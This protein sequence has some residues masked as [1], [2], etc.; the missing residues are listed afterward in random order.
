LADRY[1]IERELGRGGM[2][3]VWL[4]RDL[5][6]DRSIALKVLH[7]ELA[8]ALGPDRFLR[9]IR[10]AAGLQHPHILP[11]HDSGSADGLLWYTMPYV[12]GESLRGRLEREPQLPLEE[13]VRIG[14]E[15]ADGLSY[16]HRQGIIHRDIKPENILLSDGH[17]LIADFGLARA[18]EAAGADRLTESGIAVGTPAYMSPEQASC[19]ARL[20]A[21]SDLYALGCVVYEMLAG[22]PPFQG[23]TAQ[24]I[25][26]RRMSEPVRPLRPVRNVPESVER[27]VLTALERSPADRF[28]DVAVFSTALRSALATTGSPRPGA[29]R[30]L[31]TLAIAGSAGAAFLA[32]GYL[33]SRASTPAAPTLLSTGVLRNRERLLIA[34]FDNRTADSLLGPAVTEAFRTDLAGS[35]VIGVV[36]GAKVMATLERMRRPRTARLDAELA[37]EVA[38]RDGIKAVVTG[39][40]GYAGGQYL[41][42]AQLMATSTGDVLVALRET[43][44]DSSRIVS[45]IDRLSGDLR[46][47]IG[48]SVR[49]VRAE[50]PLDQVTTGSLLALWK[51]SEG[52]RAGDGEGDFA[53][54]VALLE[55]A[56]ALDTAFATAYRTLGG[57]YS[58]LGDRKREV[59]AL[60][61]AH[62]HRGRLSEL[63]LAHTQAHYH[64]AVTGDLHQAASA[65]RA[66]LERHPDDSVAINNLGAMALEMN[67]PAVAESIFRGVDTVRPCAPSCLPGGHLNLATALIALG[68]RSEAERVYARG[69]E[70]MPRSRAMQW[71][72][73]S[74]ASSA[75]DYEAAEARARAIKDRYASD[76][77]DR[78]RASR[79]LAAIALTR[80]RLAEAEREIGEALTASVEAGRQE[81]YLRDVAALGYI[82][83]WFRGRPAQGRR[84]VDAAVARYPLSSI[85]V[86]ERPYLNLALFYAAA[87]QP[88]RAR[89]LLRAYEGD[90]QP[91]LRR[92]NE[93]MRRWTWGHVALAEHRFPEAIAAFRA[94]LRSFSNCLPCGQAALALAYDRAGQTDSAIVAYER[95]VETP[96]SRLGYPGFLDDAT[97][98]APALRRLGELYQARGDHV[99][100]AAY[101][102]RFAT[103]WE[104]ADPELRPAVTAAREEL[105]HLDRED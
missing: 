15:I 66:V 55:E 75:G 4:A 74:L 10:V 41:L 83:T 61:K 60:T 28:R 79:G 44:P 29:R 76:P 82:E 34:D 37:R 104:H 78:A 103:L 80:G 59:A 105:A 32:A 57:F 72:G 26:A 85:E 68:R 70:Q 86:L 7:P 62:D 97:Q 5:R 67:Q 43:A 14:A 25:I 13:A 45:A 92:M 56:V 17:C 49:T 36:S 88:D 33:M 46:A 18:L 3:T 73:I 23:R 84:V 69:L 21:R 81:A 35:S 89:A 16:A 38:L 19:D 54:G 12:P 63:E 51:Y 39:Q 6:H 53:R 87:D 71:F 102:S 64:L 24:A 8:H 31:V 50:P 30:R 52:L 100:A 27:V 47:R 93:P 40:V 1:Q 11:V 48:E 101:Y 91:A 22:E 94:Y 58:N 96:A 77:L 98:L 95:Y 90:V 42:S 9:E 65:Y 2:A 20:D 99:K